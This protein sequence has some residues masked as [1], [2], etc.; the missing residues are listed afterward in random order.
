MKTLSLASAAAL[1]FALAPSVGAQT[2]TTPVAECGPITGT[3]S[4]PDDDVAPITPDMAR[5]SEDDARAA[6]QRAVPG[7][8]VTDVDLEEEDGFLVYEADLWRD[9][10]EF[11]VTVDAGSGEVLCTEQ[12]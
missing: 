4:V 8:T 6:A 7:A 11:D 12:D 10:V 2:A 9:G 3:I 5:V 1:A